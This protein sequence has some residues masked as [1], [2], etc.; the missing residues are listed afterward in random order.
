MGHHHTVTVREL[1]LVASKHLSNCALNPVSLDRAPHLPRNHHAQAPLAPGGCG[2]SESASTEPHA[3]FSHPLKFIG[4]SYARR[5]GKALHN[6]VNGSIWCYLHLGADAT[7]VFGP[8]P[9]KNFAP[10]FSLH[11]LTEAMFVFTF[12]LAGLKRSFH[13]SSSS[14]MSVRLNSMLHPNSKVNR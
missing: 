7:P 14:L 5:L 6:E 3:L 2:H 4:A 10:A 13:N 8:A 9:G 1:S 12:A 11:P